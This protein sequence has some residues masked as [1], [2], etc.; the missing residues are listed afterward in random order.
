MKWNKKIKVKTY[1]KEY[2]TREREIF[3]FWPLTI[4]NVTRWFE[5]AKVEEIFYYGTSYIF[6][7][8]SSPVTGKWY[9]KR[10]LD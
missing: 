7:D 10:W 5:Y 6:V 1:P 3:L 9:M 4:D 2:E 8:E